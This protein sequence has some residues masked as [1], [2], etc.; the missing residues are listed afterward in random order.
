MA[1][2]DF[3]NFELP[4]RGV[5]LTPIMVGGYDGDPNDAGA[6]D[7]LKYAP[8]GA[9]YYEASERR[10]W[11]KMSSVAGDWLV[12]GGVGT[13]E[14]IGEIDFYVRAVDGDDSNPGTD[15]EPF[16]TLIEAERRIPF[17]VNHTVRIHLGLHASNGYVWPTFRQRVGSK[18]IWIIGDGGGGGTD[19]F[20]EI[21]AS[22]AAGSGSDQDVIKTTGLSTTEYGGF[23]EL[24]GATIEILTGLAAGDFRLVNKNTATDI[25][26]A[27]QF[28]DVVSPGDLYRIVVPETII[29]QDTTT[30]P[31]ASISEGYGYTVRALYAPITPKLVFENVRFDTSDSTTV[32]FRGSNSCIMLCGAY[33]NKRL[34]LNMPN[35]RILSGLESDAGGDNTPDVVSAVLDRGAPNNK[36][37]VGWGLSSRSTSKEGGIYL[38]GGVELIGCVTA[39]TLQLADDNTAMVLHLGSIW[40]GPNGGGAIVTYNKSHAEIFGN[41]YPLFIGTTLESS[42][43]VAVNGPG[44]YVLLYGIDP[45]YSGKTM[46]VMNASLMGIK[47]TEAKCEVLN[48]FSTD[49]S[50]NAPGG[51]AFLTNTKGQIQLTSISGIPDITALGFSEDNGNTVRD[52]SLLTMG[53]VYEDL[54]FGY[55]KRT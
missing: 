40:G 34:F 12:A 54:H 21:I 23:G 44:S 25:I 9:E 47:C 43:S 39:P 46:I 28:S 7:V 11:R 35:S 52:I 20:I 24:F 41:Y 16:A 26:P 33:C 8:P 31:A 19:G 4:R 13:Y 50:I 3:V 2:E 32:N 10:F 36:S 27:Y 45:S 17:H 53:A 30:V 15:T 14:T 48:I 49:I 29:Y 5:T 38:Q 51:M 1:F 18:N 55:V 6:P 22:T 42:I 37:Y